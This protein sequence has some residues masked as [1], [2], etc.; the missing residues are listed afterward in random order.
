MSPI[1]SLATALDQSVASALHQLFKDG[2][3][4]GCRA[5]GEHPQQVDDNKEACGRLIPWVSSSRRRPV[6]I[7]N[8][9]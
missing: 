5:S 3:G 6:A 8:M 2:G 4:D 9:L 1:V 7:Q